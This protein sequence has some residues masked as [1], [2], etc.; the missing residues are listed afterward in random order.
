[1]LNRRLS[2]RIWDLNI[3]RHP[4]Y[5]LLHMMLFH[6]RYYERNQFWIY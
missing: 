6:V 3:T 2:Y 5:F 1:M 4:A